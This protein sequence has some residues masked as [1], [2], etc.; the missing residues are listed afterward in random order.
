MWVPTCFC[1]TSL[2]KAVREAGLE[3][4]INWHVLNEA[5]SVECWRSFINYT[6]TLRKELALDNA[7]GRK[8]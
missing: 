1:N 4:G 3:Y 6:A 7:N 5:I 2:N 8:E